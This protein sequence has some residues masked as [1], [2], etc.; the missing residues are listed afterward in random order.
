M[1]SKTMQDALNKQLQAEYKAFYTYLSM[2]A[3][4]HRQNLDGFAGWMAAQSAEE[5]GHAQRLFNYIL[6]R[7]GEVELHELSAPKKD[8]ESPI[9]AMQSALEH[10][11]KVTS[12][13]ND[14][15]SQAVEENDNATRIFL[16]WFVTEQVE[17]EAS[18]GLAVEKLRRA[19]ED[20]PSL[21]MLDREFGARVA[22]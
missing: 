12:M 20:L 11:K 19:G 17:E 2:Q 1:L 6:E 3:Y 9:A 22:E 16:H 18:A 21:L 4:Y 7:N 14:L 15:F 5:A 10:E 13:I 8:W